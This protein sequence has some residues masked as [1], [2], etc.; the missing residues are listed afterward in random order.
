MIRKIS[1]KFVEY[2]SENNYSEQEKDEMEY[3]LNTM[4]FD[5]IKLGLTFIIFTVL[6]YS[7]QSMIVLIT[8]SLIK[9]YIGGYHEESQFKCFV[10]TILLTAGIIFMSTNTKFS[11]YSNCIVILFC[12]YCMYNQVPIINPNMPITRPHLIVKNRKKGLCNTTIIGISSIVMYKYTCFYCIITWVIIVQT[13]LLFNKK[14][15][16]ER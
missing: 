14:Q 7:C 2:I 3:I 5:A 10:S 4:I 11:F 6:G 12:L 9:P 16:K 15:F 13:L 8:M 1:K